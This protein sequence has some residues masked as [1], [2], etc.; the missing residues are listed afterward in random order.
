MAESGQH[1]QEYNEAVEKL[2]QI[3]AETSQAKVHANQLIAEAQRIVE[4]MG[5]A[6]T[7]VADV[8]SK[9]DLTNNRMQC[10]KPKVSRN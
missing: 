3:D 9:T 4:E 10:S 8:T 1:T 2:G 5:D 6:F 7:Q